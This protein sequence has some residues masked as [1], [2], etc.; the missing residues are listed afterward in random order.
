MKKYLILMYAR[1]KQHSL[2]D[3]EERAVYYQKW[4][5]HL[6]QFSLDDRFEGGS[7]LKQ[8]YTLIKSDHEAVQQGELRA[9]FILQADGLT[10]LRARL[11]DSP[12]LERFEGELHIHEMDPLAMI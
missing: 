8:S 2:L 12:L 4:G 5:Q 1:G 11:S 10:A 9:Y 7:P 6:A 3:P